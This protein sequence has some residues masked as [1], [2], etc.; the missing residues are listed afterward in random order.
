MVGHYEM[1]FDDVVYVAEHHGGALLCFFFSIDIGTS[2]SVGFTQDFVTG[3]LEWYF[4]AS[5]VDETDGIADV[6]TVYYPTKAIMKIYA[7]HHSAGGTGRGNVIADTL[8]LHFRPG[9]ARVVA[10]HLHFDGHWF[11]SSYF[12]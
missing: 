12:C 9:E 3:N 11:T 1:R 4:V 5:N 7:F 2:P 10:P 8:N 6:D